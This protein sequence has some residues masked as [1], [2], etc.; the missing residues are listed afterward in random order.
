M[1]CSPIDFIA[2][3][4]TSAEVAKTGTARRFASTSANLLR[5]GPLILADDLIYV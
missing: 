1:F 5:Q 3:G 2:T 4:S